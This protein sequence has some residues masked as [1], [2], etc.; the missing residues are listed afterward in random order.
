MSEPLSGATR[1][2]FIVGDPIAQ[3]K[4]PA[5]VSQAFHDKGH[6]AYVMPAHVAPAQ[7]AAWLAGVS[8]AQNVDG[9][10]VTVPH[11]FA[12]HDLCASTSDRAAFLHIV[13]TMRRNP[14]GSWHGDMFD[15][16]GFVSAM[17][18]NGCQPAGKKALLVGAGGAGSAI[19]HALV[20]AGVSS[21]AI[22][23]PDAAR[24]STLVDRL[25]GLGKCPVTH[26]SADPTG[27][28]I[29]LNAS[30]VGMQASD[31]IPVDADKLQ[32]AMFVGCVITAPAITPLIAAARAKGCQTMTGAHMFGRVRDLMVDFLLE[33]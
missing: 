31:P 30:P 17:Q 13:N 32:A 29:V 2:H 20:V 1:V 9:V 27:F 4:S 15:G 28:D 18:D 33:K 21:L 7:L 12:C 22:H 8:L 23:D 25:A 19:A 11:K 14:D 26:G 24:R 16:L 10:I 5:G 3:V 6:N